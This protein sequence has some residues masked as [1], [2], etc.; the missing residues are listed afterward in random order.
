MFFS[1]P[2]S[3]FAAAAHV[4]VKDDSIGR[5]AE[6]LLGHAQYHTGTMFLV[7]SQP[8]PTE[9]LNN[10]QPFLLFWREA[11]RHENKNNAASD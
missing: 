7:L 11:F 2:E 10:W 3:H 4:N 9:P 6:Q 1:L 8:E 5:Y